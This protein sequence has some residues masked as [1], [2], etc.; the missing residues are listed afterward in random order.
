[1]A[2]WFTKRSISVW[3]GCV[4]QGYSPISRENA[5]DV[6]AMITLSKFVVLLAEVESMVIKHM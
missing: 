2:V 3:A 5:G 4:L 1:M 6:P